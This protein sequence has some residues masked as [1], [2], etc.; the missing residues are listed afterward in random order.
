MSRR[1]ARLVSGQIFKRKTGGRRAGSSRS[2]VAASNESQGQYTDDEQ[3]PLEDTWGSAAD[4]KPMSQRKTASSFRNISVEP[5]V[6]ART[7]LTL[8]SSQE[9]QGHSSGY[10][11]SEEGYYRPGLSECVCV[12]VCVRVCLCVC[13]HRVACI[14][15]CLC[16]YSM[17]MILY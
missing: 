16:I 11:S 9:V 17:R 13:V 7:G 10:S 12:C 3:A 1:S 5:I 2:S 15:V 8:I 14:S 4:Y 6:S